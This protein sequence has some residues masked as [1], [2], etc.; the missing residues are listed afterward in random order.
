MK[1]SDIFQKFALSRAFRGRPYDETSRL[2]PTRFG[3]A[4]FKQCFE[5]FALLVIDNFLRNTNMQAAR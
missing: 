2:F 1:M 5:P 3:Q 4:V